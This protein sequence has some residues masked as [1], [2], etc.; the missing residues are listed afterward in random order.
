MKKIL[1]FIAVLAA[2]AGAVW[3][4]GFTSDEKRRSLLRKGKSAGYDAKFHLQRATGS[5]SSESGA[6][7]HLAEARQCGK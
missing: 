7:E 2:I 1:L 4:F 3:Y 5:L 6:S